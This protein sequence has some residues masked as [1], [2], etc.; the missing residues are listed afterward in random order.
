MKNPAVIDA[1]LG[2][3]HDVDLGD[4]EGIKELEGELEADEESVVGTENA[5]I[6][7]KEVVVQEVEERARGRHSHDDAS[8][9]KGTE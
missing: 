9:E 6:I 7:A 2:A 5:G 8:R 4:A 3:H 1:Y